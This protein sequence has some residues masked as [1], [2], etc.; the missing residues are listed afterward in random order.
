LF[1]LKKRPVSLHYT[2]ETLVFQPK[3]IFSHKRKAQTVKS[4]LLVLF[5]CHGF[6]GDAIHLAQAI[7]TDE[8]GHHRHAGGRTIFEVFPEYIRAPAKILC[9]FDIVIQLHHILKRGTHRGQ[10]TC[11]ALQR[12]TSLVHQITHILS[13]AMVSQKMKSPA[14]TQEEQVSSPQ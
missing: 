12:S 1:F 3:H 14:T 6:I 2:E 8:F 13:A 4:T 7:G 5:S 9:A 11:H 10:C